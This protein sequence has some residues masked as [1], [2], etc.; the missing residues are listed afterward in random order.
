[1]SNRRV[2][3][4]IQ[5]VEALD[6]MEGIVSQFFSKTER[7]EF[8]SQPVTAQTAAFFRGWSRKE[9][10]LKA[11]GTGW[12][13]PGR[14]ADVSMSPVESTR[15]HFAREPSGSPTLWTIHDLAPAPGF[16]GAIA[17]EGRIDRLQDY[18]F[19]YDQ[20]IKY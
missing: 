20:F 16:V 7:D 9:A 4:D 15:S 8:E 13:G 3:I 2:G 10:W 12:A 18:E 1:A 6:R 5:F 19:G 17:V 11:V 14:H